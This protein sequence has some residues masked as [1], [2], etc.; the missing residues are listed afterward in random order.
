MSTKGRKISI[1]VGISAFNEERNIK[2]LIDS[3]LWQKESRYTIKEIIVISD[4][5]TDQTAMCLQKIKDHRLK[6]VNSKKRF[7]KTTRL[8]WIFKNA[9][10]DAIVIF[11]A[12]VVLSAR[13]VIE[14]LVKPLVNEENVGF[15]CGRAKPIKGKTFIE[16]CV[17]ASHD[18]YDNFRSK[19]RK[20]SNPYSVEGRVMLLSKDFASKVTL[21]KP[22]GGDKY[23]YFYCITNGFNFRYVKAA[24]VL[25][26]SP[27]TLSE[28]IRQN[29]RFMARGFQADLIF[30]DIVS[31]EF[32]I[33]KKILVVSFLKTFIEKPIYSI[34]IFFINLYCKYKAKHEWK[35]INEKWDI[36]STTKAQISK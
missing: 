32:K 12:D 30:G 23:L 10:G 24:T 8:N 2:K 33:S 17:N 20:G 14:N 11:D 31:K 22:Y 4:G 28:H 7:G 9:K 25:Y 27:S 26:R 3:I 18:A 16:N 29:T 13:D 35:N 36:V 21:T 15:I 34:S 5:S 1:S 6:I 19:L